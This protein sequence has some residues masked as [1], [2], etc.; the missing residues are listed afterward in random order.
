MAACGAAG[1]TLRSR[2]PAVLISVAVHG[3]LLAL[4][5]HLRYETG[6]PS[7]ANVMY[8]ELVRL[9][10]RP[11]ANLGEEPTPSA[12][13]PPAPLPDTP[14]A[15]EDAAAPPLGVSEP[16]DDAPDEPTDE[17]AAPPEPARPAALPEPVRPAA[18]SEP[19]QRA[20]AHEPAREPDG[21]RVP[22]P[23]PPARPALDPTSSGE[24]R[25]Q[26]VVDASVAPAGPDAPASVD[27]PGAPESAVPASAGALDSADTTAPADPADRVDAPATAVGAATVADEPVDD[28]TTNASVASEPI[29][30]A[31]KQQQMI[32]KRFG[33]WTARTKG[34]PFEPVTWKH[35][36]REYAAAFRP[37]PA[38]DATGIDRLI[39]EVRTQID[40][41]DVTTE[42]RMKRLPF[43]SFA[44]LVDRWNPEVQIHDDEID[45]RFHSNTEINV[46]AN[47]QARP[48]FRGRV[49]TASGSIRSDSFGPRRE[50]F[51]EGLET[52]VRRIALPP[53]FAPFARGE[54]PAEQVRRFSADTRIVFR[55]DGTYEYSPLEA[56]GPPEVGSLGTGAHYLIAEDGAQLHVSGTVNGQVL[57]YSPRDIV[58]ERN[59]VYGDDPRIHP[60]S[61]HFIGLVSDRS[62]AVAEPE[63]TGPGDLTIHASV[64]AKSQFAVHRYRSRPSGTLY[65]YGSVSAGSITATEPRYGTK[66]EYDDRLEHLR[67]PGFPFTDRYELEAWDGAWR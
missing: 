17:R 3:S 66:I 35:D 30:A 67:A 32:E 14:N 45:G 39:V 50:M 36:G 55:P 41:R 53:R 43:S 46:L 19:V 49:T 2:A 31:A 26:R 10:P 11:D 29:V 61:E 51:L 44:Q 59:L 56:A 42:L 40:G 33:S 25:Q 57:V 54:P 63:V 16:I 58:I 12:D 60:D 20:A 47:G 48:V 13:E 52:G 7:T 23:P 62:V 27:P 65:I 6:A 18:V 5:A 28:A 24:P 4:L 38:N 64:F 21:E 15:A 37:L 8:A 22:A 1:V 34:E 9:A